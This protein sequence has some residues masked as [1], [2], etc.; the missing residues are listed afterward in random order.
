MNSKAQLAAKDIQFSIP[1]HNLQKQ[2]KINPVFDP[3]PASS[4][5]VV[6]TVSV[7]KEKLDD[8]LNQ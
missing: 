3:Y 1:R 8:I 4:E 7:K 6:A 5:A 2:A